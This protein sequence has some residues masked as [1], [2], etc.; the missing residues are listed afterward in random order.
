M[1]N[2]SALDVAPSQTL[3]VRGS[4]GGLF[5]QLD[6][7]LDSAEATGVLEAFPARQ[8]EHMRVDHGGIYGLSNPL[9]E[10]STT[11]FM[12]DWLD[13]NNVDSKA[14]GGNGEVLTKDILAQT[15]DTRPFVMQP[16]SV[17]TLINAE[18]LDFVL[19]YVVKDE[20]A[21]ANLLLTD[22]FREKY[23]KLHALTS[24]ASIVNSDAFN[25]LESSGFLSTSRSFD[26]FET[27]FTFHDPLSGEMVERDV[28]Y[29]PDESSPLIFPQFSDYATCVS[30]WTEY[31]AET[32]HFL[33]LLFGDQEVANLIRYGR[34]NIDYQVQ[35][36]YAVRTDSAPSAD[37]TFYMANHW[38]TWPSP[39]ESPDPLAYL[40]EYVTRYEGG[41]DNGFRLDP[42]SIS[43]N[44]MAVNSLSPLLFNVNENP[45]HPMTDFL[46]MEGDDPEALLQAAV[47]ALNE[48]PAS[49][50]SWRKRT[51]N[52]TR[53]GQSN[54]RLT[55]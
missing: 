50:V 42:T 14:L 23:K 21:F 4:N 10:L 16:G 20:Q 9:R 35:D 39:G 26:Q 17:V 5:R 33:G 51:G 8:I 18:H 24:E 27:V 1:E 34:E 45:S 55:V 11:V 2:V 31:E 15:S 40:N 44:I 54:L 38:L 6:E 46:K 41:I 3:Y 36:G 25:M 28:L 22:H 47:D 32:L 53:N 13:N 52:W 29:V 19:S 30:A 43:S 48:K 49:N 7:W 37:W 12:K